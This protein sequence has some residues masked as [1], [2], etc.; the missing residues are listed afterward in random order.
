MVQDFSNRLDC[1]GTETAFL[2]SKDANEFASKGNKI[3]PFH[4]G[5]INITTPKNI[6]EKSEFAMKDGK[7]GYV[8]SEGIPALRDALAEKLGDER[9][10]NLTRDNIIVQ[11][12]G[13][14]VILKFIHSLMDPGDEVLYPNPGYPIYESQIE[15]NG[16]IAKAYS[17]NLSNSGF[18]IDKKQLENSINSKTKILVYNNYQ[19]PMGSESSEE[20]MNWIADFAIKNNLWV[21][22]DEAYFNIQYSGTPKSI[23]SIPGMFERTVILY[24]FS[25]T[26]AM[27]GWRLGAAVGPKPLMKYFSKLSVNDE[28]CTNHFIQYGGVEALLGD[29]SGA[30]YILTKLKKRRDL[31]SKKLKQINGVNLYVPNSTFYLFPEITDIYD[32]MGAKSYEDFRSKTLLNTGVAFCTREHFGRVDD[33]ESKKFIRFAYSGINCDQI[34]EGID[35]LSTFWASL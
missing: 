11:P 29:Q 34:D 28:S 31:L 7:T 1:L 5:D 32:K 23:I 4:L 25:K 21:L 16:G 8:P 13:K 33:N 9:N 3:Y 20:E 27:T 6:I 2:V 15:Y 12:G 24:T 35:K 30:N 14:P 19:N 26:Y 18:S 17:Y 10:I 22:S